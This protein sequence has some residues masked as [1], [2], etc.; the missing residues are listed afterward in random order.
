M[1][2]VVRYYNKFDRDGDVRPCLV[3][4]KFCKIF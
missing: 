1:S 4:K 3:P 2:Q